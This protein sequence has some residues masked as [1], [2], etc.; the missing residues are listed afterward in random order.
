VPKKSPFR[1]IGIDEEL[2]LLVERK[3]ASMHRR[4]SFTAFVE[5][6]LDL[7]CKGIL[8]DQDDRSK[9]FDMAYAKLERLVHKVGG[10]KAIIE[11]EEKR[12][13]S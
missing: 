8:V 3:M 5:W 9:R 1:K 7:Y 2:A 13:A 6:V 10:V 12:A 4:D 11:D